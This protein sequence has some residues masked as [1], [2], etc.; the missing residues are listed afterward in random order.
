VKRLVILLALVA[1]SKAKAT[2]PAMNT[3]SLGALQFPLTEGTP[4]ARAHFTRGLLALHSF[5]Y[6]EARREFQAAID[7][8]RTMNMAYWGLALSYCKLLWG[9]DDVVAAKAALQKMPDPEKLSDREQAWVFA[10]IALLKSP[11]VISSRKA[12]VQTMTAVNDKY[13]DDESATFLSIALLSSSRPEDLNHLAIRQR[14]AELAAGVFAKNPKHP[15]AAHYLIHAY[16][17]PD[18][19]K[20]GLP[21]AKAYAEIAP[22]AFHAR[23]MP[24]HIYA[25]LGMWPEAIA[26]CRAA[27]DASLSAAKAAKLS[28]NHHDFH[29]LSWLVE[30]PFELGNR[31]DAEAALTTFAT[32]VKAGLSHQHRA[33]YAAEVASFMMRT[34]EWSRIDELLAPLQAPAADDPAD[35][36]YCGTR[37]APYGQFEQLAVLDARARAAS[38]RH[39]VPATEQLV[40]QIDELRT[41]LHPFIESTQPPEA[42][43]RADA[44]NARSRRAM[45]A[46][47]ANDDAALVTVL[48]ESAADADLDA[49]GESNPSA[50]S[51]RDELGE[52]LL[53]LGKP[54]EAAVVFEKELATHPNRARTM[55]GLAKAKR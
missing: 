21:Y 8:D 51:I 45:L 22:A 27:W 25:R 35:G 3:A 23:H 4:A 52:A 19:A 31:K 50:F 47:A 15:G 18:L 37:G 28:P 29:S 12:F 16:D 43:A 48:Q 55:A 32:A 54:A 7:T 36:T 41:Q 11:D 5:W 39:D 2:E 9:E 40:K 6:D 33:L 30:M 17:T 14:A 44:A 13:P 49:T 34:D 46:R 42:V 38:Y 26:S 10:L 1:C 24:A 20:Q 53:R